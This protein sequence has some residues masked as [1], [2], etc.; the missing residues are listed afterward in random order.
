M[1]QITSDR[2]FLKEIPFGPGCYIYKSSDA[3]VL[4]V[5]KAVNLRSRVSS[6]FTRKEDLEPKIRIMLELAENIEII[7][8]D[9][10]IEALIL[11]TNLIK[12]YRPK[13]NRMM[14][15]DKNYIWVMFDNKSDFPKPQI[16][17]EKNLK[18]AVYFGPY[19]KIFPASKVLRRLRRLFPYCNK[20]FKT[21]YIEEDGRKTLIGAEV[22]PC[23]DYHIGLCSGVCAG[24]VSRNVHRK[25]ID[26]V[27]R[28]FRGQKHEIYNELSES[29]VKLSK[30]KKFEEAAKTRDILSDLDYVTQRIKIDTGVDES[31]LREKMKSINLRSIEELKARLKIRNKKSA[32]FKIECYD[33]SNIQGTNATASMVV[34]IG[35]KAKR[36]YYRKFKIKVKSTPD[37]F[38]M[39]QEVLGRRLK[40]SKTN[41]G[42]KKKIIDQS[43]KVLPDLIIVD[44]GKGQLSSAWD[45]LNKLKM[46]DKL[47]IVGLA[48]REEEI[49]RLKIEGGEKVFKKIIL[50]RRSDPLYLVQR[51]RDE[52]HRFAIGYHRKLRSKAGSRSLLDDVP[53]IGKLTKKRLIRAF[54]SLENIKKAGEKELQTVVRNKRT[55][56]AIRKLV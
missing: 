23:L 30:E 56:R 48:K 49:F 5:G 27:K 35:G 41:R 43:F 4:Y 45:V 31:V 55:V 40:H 20:N 36:D 15:D 52:A 29:M 11:E 10:E 14:K 38:L 34:F 54:G 16:V 25:N 3:K 50:P 1:I 19:P 24:L 17:R 39:M 33:I 22:R 26:N 21:K 9:S 6:Y 47:P 32:N 2:K 42:N 46:T 13:Y 18:N 44:G 51:I 53:G 7:E 37:D 12:K 28:F 8:V